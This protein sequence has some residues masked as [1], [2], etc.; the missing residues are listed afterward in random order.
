MVKKYRF[1]VMLEGLD[2]Q[3]GYYISYEVIASDEVQAQSIARADALESG[4]YIVACEEVE[5][6]GEYVDSI[7]EAGILKKFGKSYF[8]KDE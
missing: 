6:Q 8:D 1:I 4:L 2:G 5:L 3:Y 7:P